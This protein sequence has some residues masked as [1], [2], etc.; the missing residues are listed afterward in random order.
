[1]LLTSLHFPDAFIAAKQLYRNLGT[2]DIMKQLSQSSNFKESIRLYHSL[3]REKSVGGICSI[4]P[5][6][7]ADYSFVHAQTYTDYFKRSRAFC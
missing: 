2:A 5:L 4:K 3:I 7:H 6:Q 1:V